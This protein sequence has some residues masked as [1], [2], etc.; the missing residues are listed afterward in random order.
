MPEQHTMMHLWVADW[1]AYSG[2]DR[3]HQG[4]LLGWQQVVLHGL[5]QVV[6]TSTAI[7]HQRFLLHPLQKSRMF[8]HFS[9]NSH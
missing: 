8:V 9:A 4:A 5:N 1:R 3:L 2:A 6:F 7:L